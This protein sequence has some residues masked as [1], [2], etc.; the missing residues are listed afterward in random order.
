MKHP[1]EEQ[2]ILHHY[3][4]EADFSKLAEHLETCD[5]CRASYQAIQRVLA[6]VDSIPVPE[7]TEQYGTEVWRQL[8]PQLANQEYA[9]RF[10]WLDAFRRSRLPRWALAGGLALAVLAAFLAGRFW[11]EKPGAPSPAV[12]QAAQ[13]LSVEARERVLLAEIGDHLERS[14]LALV[15]LINSRTNGPVDISAEQVLARELI[16]M[17]RLFRRAATDSG[18]PGMASVLESVELVLVEVAN[19]PAK[20]SAEEFAALRQQIDP[21]DLLF[22]VRVVTAQVRAR[23]RDLVR[24]MTAKRS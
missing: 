21:D 8:R 22:K 16:A 13:P 20:L 24:E 18:E 3:R 1:S 4:E 5:A 7:R 14:Q 17:N 9:P 15:E 23:E 12:A 2:L 11:Q 10:G 6:T 19:G